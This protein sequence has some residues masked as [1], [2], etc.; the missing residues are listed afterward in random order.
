M[1]AVFDE[2][3]KVRAHLDEY[4][5][6]EGQL[7]QRIQQTMEHHSHAQ[8]L[9]GSVSWKKTAD[10]QVLDSKRLSQE[11]PDLV[12]RYF[13]TRAGSRRFTVLA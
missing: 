9:H 4:K 1:N 8:F 12:A 2:L 11:H 6:K 13:T 10:A 7:K 3:V 5:A